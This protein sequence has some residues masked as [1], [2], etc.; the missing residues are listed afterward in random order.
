MRFKFLCA[1]ALVL[2]L[3]SSSFAAGNL[4]FIPDIRDSQVMPPNNYICQTMLVGNKLITFR[5]WLDIPYV[6]N[7]V[8]PEYHRLN[9]YIPEEYFHEGATING[10]TAKTAP[11]LMPNGVGGYMPGRAFV[12][13]NDMR[14]GG[15][16][17]ALAA[18]AHGYVVIAP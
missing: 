12:P 4:A 3:S 16:N 8:E 17:I 1:L 2:A 13:A 7:P 10:Y 18:L 11:I 14:H 6:S 9:V 15:P 5:S